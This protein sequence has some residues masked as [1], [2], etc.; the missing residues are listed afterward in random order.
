VPIEERDEVADRLEGT[1]DRR[2]FQRVLIRRT[3]ER[4]VRAV[5][6]ND[7]APDIDTKIGFHDDRHHDAASIHGHS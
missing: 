7:D 1:L 6:V 5:P 4:G 2:R 3:D